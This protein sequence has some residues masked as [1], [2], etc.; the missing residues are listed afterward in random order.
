M[1]GILKFIKMRPPLPL[2]LCFSSLLLSGLQAY[3]DDDFEDFDQ[4]AV[5]NTE[6]I[7]PVVS[8]FDDDFVQL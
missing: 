1:S 8:D 3:P 5:Y 2:I 6:V 7:S 4:T